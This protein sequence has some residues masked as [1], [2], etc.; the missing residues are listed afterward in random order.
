MVAYNAVCN[1]SVAGVVLRKCPPS[2][3]IYQTVVIMISPLK[4]CE[5]LA[6]FLRIRY[7]QYLK[8]SSIL[9][10]FKAFQSCADPWNS[11]ASHSADY[12][13]GAS[14]NLLGLGFARLARS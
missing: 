1:S 5:P 7:T 4:S 14:F 9:R 12:F 10:S 2:A 8:V 6:D 3:P 11:L 13:I